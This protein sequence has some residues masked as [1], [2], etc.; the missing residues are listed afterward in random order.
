ML[1]G[2]VEACTWNAAWMRA[3]SS[4][5]APA[6]RSATGPQP[7]LNQR[8]QIECKDGLPGTGYWSPC[9]IPSPAKS[10]P[11]TAV[12][13]GHPPRFAPGTTSATALLAVNPID[14]RSSGAAVSRYRPGVGRARRRGCGM[15]LFTC[16]FRSSVGRGGCR[17]LL[18]ARRYRVLRGRPAT[19]RWPAGGRVSGRPSV[20][21]IDAGPRLAGAS[22]E[23]IE[24]GVIPGCQRVVP[25]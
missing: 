19:P 21:S 23:F 7:A 11:T 17:G 1:L 5:G 13:P 2:A 16:P 8:R 4:A 20:S 12:P 6:S 9:T 3:L 25:G 18:R 10:A 15:S 14:V 24:A 22:D